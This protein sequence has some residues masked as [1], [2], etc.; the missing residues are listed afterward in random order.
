MCFPIE[1]VGHVWRCFLLSSS[2][3]FPHWFDGTIPH[4]V[5]R[6]RT[7]WAWKHISRQFFFFDTPMV[8]VTT[9]KCRRHSEC[10]KQF[11]TVTP[12]TVNDHASSV[13]KGKNTCH[14][15]QDTV[16]QTFSDII[17]K[18]FPITFSQNIFYKNCKTKDVCE[19]DLTCAWNKKTWFEKWIQFSKFQWTRGLPAEDEEEHLFQT[20]FPMQ[21]VPLIALKNVRVQNSTQTFVWKVKWMKLD[22]WTS[23]QLNFTSSHQ[24]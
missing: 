22:S 17:E 24:I 5:F 1:T 11:L 4:L 20:L 23:N 8:S 14:Q 7:H 19:I 12:S 9:K 13:G 18:H 16:A 15:C 6:D 2:A 21:F 10:D 3:R